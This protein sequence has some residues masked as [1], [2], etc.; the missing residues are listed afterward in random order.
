M[1]QG[2]NDMGIRVKTL[3]AIALALETLHHV[4]THKTGMTCVT[5]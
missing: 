1:G 2:N 3:N 5:F 4:I